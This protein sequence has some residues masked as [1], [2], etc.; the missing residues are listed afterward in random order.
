M[1]ERDPL[2][3]TEDQAERLAELMAND[4]RK[5]APLRRDVRSLG[6]LLG[7]VIREQEG[8]ELFDAVEQLRQLM[9]EQRDQ[10]DGDASTSLMER[11]PKSWSTACQCHRRMGSPGR[12]RSTS[13]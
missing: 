3:R 2:W 5:E 11:A 10:S 12:S 1:S 8:D 13:S 6:R 9:I 4:E 7:E